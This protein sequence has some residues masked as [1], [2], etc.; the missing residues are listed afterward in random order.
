MAKAYHPFSTITSAIVTEL[1]EA[2][3]IATHSGNQIFHIHQPTAPGISEMALPNL[4][5]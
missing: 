2:S 5:L 1:L 3:L 4:D